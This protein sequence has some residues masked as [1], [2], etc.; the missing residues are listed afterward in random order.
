M[1]YLHKIVT[2][3][4]V[5]L[6]I[7][8][9][10]N[11]YPIAEGNPSSSEIVWHLSD[12]EDAEKIVYFVTSVDGKLI[13]KALFPVRRDVRSEIKSVQKTFTYKF[14][15]PQK[16]S[17]YFNDVTTG[18]VEGNIWIAGGESNGL[19][20]GISWVT[21]NQIILNTL[22][23]APIDEVENTEIAPGV[24]FSTYWLTK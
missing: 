18:D 22:Q 5:I 13:D 17:R 7:V 24:I 21:G 19:I 4:F 8:T 14:I 3:S 10:T 9:A 11:C 16:N 15:L 20:F 23:F 1:I 12:Y 2:C 6:L